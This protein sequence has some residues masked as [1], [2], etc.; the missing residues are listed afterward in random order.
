MVRLIHEALVVLD[1]VVKLFLYVVLHLVGDQTRCNLISHL[2]Q[3]SEVIRREVLVS[4]FVCHFE[5]ADCVIAQFDWNEQHVADYLVQLLVHCHVVAQ[6]F[7]N[8]LV[9][10]AFEM[11][12]LSSVENLAENIRTLALL[13]WETD[14]LTQSACDHFAEQLVLNAV[15]EEH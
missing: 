7:S 10:C 15:I 14:W 9:L 5:H 1:L 13:S 12:G 11:P 8:T 4:F 3:Q 6:L 2:A